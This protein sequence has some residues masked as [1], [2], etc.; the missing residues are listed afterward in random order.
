MMV[1]PPIMSCH[2]SVLLSKRGWPCD[3]VWLGLEWGR[4]CTVPIPSLAS[5]R[6]GNVF[7]CLRSSRHVRSLSYPEYWMAIGHVERDSWRWDAIFGILFPTELPA[8]CSR[9]LDPSETRRTIY[10]SPIQPTEHEKWKIVVLGVL[11][12]QVLWW[13]ITTQ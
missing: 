8:E 11:S 7:A 5:K 2:L 9:E 3:L 12:H 6:P 1:A 4:S 13:F 10:L